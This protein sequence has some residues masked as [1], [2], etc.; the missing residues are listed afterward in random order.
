MSPIITGIKAE[1]LEK[2]MQ[3]LPE[4]AGKVDQVLRTCTTRLRKNTTAKEYYN[5]DGVERIRHVS[6][7]G[8]GLTTTLFSILHLYRRACERQDS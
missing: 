7:K 5:K 3:L 2:R 6:T 1:S 4:P 8:S